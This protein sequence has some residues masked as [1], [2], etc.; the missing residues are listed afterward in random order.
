LLPAGEG[1]KREAELLKPLKV[2]EPE[3][4]WRERW[5]LSLLL[6]MESTGEAGEHPSPAKSQ[7]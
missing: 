4:R 1:E 5:L 7:Q 6:I 3:K 2:G